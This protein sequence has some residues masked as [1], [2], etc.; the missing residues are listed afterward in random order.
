MVREVFKRSESA[1]D[2]TLRFNLYVVGFL[3]ELRKDGRAEIFGSCV[4][5]YESLMLR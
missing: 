5:P 2:R 4:L 1:C 3:F